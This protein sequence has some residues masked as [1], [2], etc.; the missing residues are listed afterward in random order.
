M[1]LAGVEGAPVRAFRFF[2]EEDTVGSG[3]D[4][5]TFDDDSIR[6]DLECLS[7]IWN[8]ESDSEEQISCLVRIQVAVRNRHFPPISRPNLETLL[9]ELARALT[10]PGTESFERVAGLFTLLCFASDSYL[11]LFGS[12]R[13]FVSQLILLVKGGVAHFYVLSILAHFAERSESA[14]RWIHSE[15]S[16]RDI[17]ALSSELD[18]LCIIEL[19]RLFATYCDGDLSPAAGECL[20]AFCQSELCAAAA[21][22][23]L[24]SCFWHVASASSGG[25]DRLIDTRL[26]PGLLPPLE[27]LGHNES[28]RYH[29]LSLWTWGIVTE[30]MDIANVP[31]RTLIECAVD[32]CPPVAG[33]ALSALANLVSW[34]AAESIASAFTYDLVVGLCARTFEKGSAFMQ[35]KVVL[36]LGFLLVH[37]DYDTMN[38]IA[39]E[40][41]I[42]E[43]IEMVLASDD[44][45]SRHFALGIVSQLVEAAFRTGDSAIFERLQ[46]QEFFGHFAQKTEPD[47]FMAERLDFLL[48]VLVA[49][50]E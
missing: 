46:E 34:E 44:L 37:V 41:F 28:A 24:V 26:F 43:I 4:V 50:T 19:V 16:P 13:D 20:A 42:D 5:L 15:V 25:I 22:T 40:Q 38:M 9:P 1:S 10:F 48:S 36:L 31:L 47:E 2:L 32:Q 49:G 21:A 18:E 7:R 8:H 14:R 35:G 11:Q 17:T 45:N 30:R 27:S 6:P 39:R 23:Q 12:D 29:W 33:T 3:M